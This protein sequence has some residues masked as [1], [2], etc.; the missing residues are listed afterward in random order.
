MK[1]SKQVKAAKQKLAS[2]FQQGHLAIIDV[3]YETY[4]MQE[5]RKEKIYGKFLLTIDLTE[6]L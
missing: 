1:F 4:D 3:D 2:Q 5:K 6:K